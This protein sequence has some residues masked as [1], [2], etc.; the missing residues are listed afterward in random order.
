MTAEASAT[1]S[2]D[3][4][5][6]DRKRILVLGIGNT[7]LSDEGVGVHAIRRLGQESEACSDFALMDGGTLG[8]SILPAVEEADCL[9][10]VDAAR[11][12]LPPGAVRR[13]SGLRMDRLVRAGIRTCHEVGLKDLLDLARLDGRLPRCRALIAV[14]PLSLDWGTCLSPTVSLALEGAC[15]LVRATA[16]RWLMFRTRPVT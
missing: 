11:L 12:G 13:F 15:A 9:I 14:E 3:N 6:T 16:A 7:L 4:R 2:A 1:G 5:S 8:L 10:V